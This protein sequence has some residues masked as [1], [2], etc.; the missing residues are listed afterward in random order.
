[1]LRFS[2]ID[3]SLQKKYQTAFN[4]KSAR[5]FQAPVDLAEE[6]DEIRANEYKTCSS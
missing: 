2:Q 4:T 1:M 6:T 5:I 3:Y